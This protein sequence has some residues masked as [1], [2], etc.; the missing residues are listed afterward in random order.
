V[1]EWVRR[2][3]RS[4]GKKCGSVAAVVKGTPDTA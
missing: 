2:G 1:G 3:G 4:R